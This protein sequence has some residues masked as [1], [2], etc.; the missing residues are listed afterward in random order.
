[1]SSSSPNR[2]DALRVPPPISGLL[3]AGSAV[4]ITA[5]MV[6]MYTIGI[7]TN[8]TSTVTA[9]EAKRGLADLLRRAERGEH[10][11]VTRNGEPVAAIVPLRKRAGGFL[12]GKV[13]ESDATWW[14]PDDDLAESFGL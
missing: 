3:P 14:H 5:L 4:R 2:F 11:I 7:V 13:T 9:A 10:I 1:M 12:T 8:M 6:I